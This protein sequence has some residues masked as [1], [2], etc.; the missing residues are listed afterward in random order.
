M[1]LA[2]VA[3]Q[4]GCDLMTADGVGEKAGNA[5]IENDNYKAL[6]CRVR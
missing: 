4:T 5:K 1:R 6:N 3:E 2:G